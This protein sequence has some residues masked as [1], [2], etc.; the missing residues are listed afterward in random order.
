MAVSIDALAAIARISDSL[1]PQ[2]GIGNFIDDF[3]GTP[4]LLAE[5]VKSWEDY[6]KSS[7]AIKDPALIPEQY[8]DPERGG[9][10]SVHGSMTPQYRNKLD[11]IID[12]SPIGTLADFA[13][14]PEGFRGKVDPSTGR[15]KPMT[16]EEGVYTAQ[17][18]LTPPALAAK[19]LI[20]ATAPKILAMAPLWWQGAARTFGGKPSLDFVGSAKRGLAFGWGQYFS[21]RRAIASGYTKAPEFRARSTI[22]DVDELATATSPQKGHYEDV[23]IGTLA[24]ELV[25]NYRAVNK[26]I[27][28]LNMKRI[29]D[30]FP[31]GTP[32]LMDDQDY[33]LLK[34]IQQEV[35]DQMSSVMFIRMNGDKWEKALRDS[36]Q[37]GKVDQHG[38]YADRGDMSKAE[39][40]R[41]IKTG[42]KIW[43]TVTQ[44]S[45][46]KTTQWDIADSLVGKTGEKLL[47][48]NA[49][50]KDYPKSMQNKILKALQDLSRNPE[51]SK[52][53]LNQRIDRIMEKLHGKGV[54]F[55]VSGRKYRPKPLTQEMIRRDFLDTMTGEDIYNM[56]RSDIPIGVSKGSWE[57]IE[58]AA[59]A[60]S[61]YLGNFG[62]SGLRYQAGS[63]SG[64]KTT[65]VWNAKRT[66][67]YVI[68]DQN[69][70]DK[71]ERK[72][73]F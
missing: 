37:H 19:G 39:V 59:K 50:F 3:I 47:D 5:S 56:I 8:Y 25:E 26:K 71:M 62:I 69:L 28:D 38:A 43:A 10:V 13:F 51:Y 30:G 7:G 20:N 46:G 4:F 67:N 27:T 72:V 53:T 1:S 34:G 24:M 45:G 14:I 65:A 15:T 42:R 23:D 32:R 29:K 2:S 63:L 36:F 68:W 73:E 66:R 40:D 16:V 9:F 48:W 22:Y 70:L 49:K 55:E 57:G 21:D 12:K 33:L 41:I 44:T 31:E 58:A 64:Q 52:V 18:I 61:L 17:N 35:E 11:E 6:Q 60:A 54:G